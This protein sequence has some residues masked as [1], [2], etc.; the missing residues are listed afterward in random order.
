[1]QLQVFA[2][3]FCNFLQI[4]ARC[5]IS[6]SPLQEIAKKL[7]KELP[8]LAALRGPRGLHIVIP[9]ALLNTYVFN[10]V[11]RTLYSKPFITLQSS[12]I[13]PITPTSIYLCEAN[14]RAS[15]LQRP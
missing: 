12:K 6:Q 15:I 10:N 14:L 3:L 13:L 7:R 11:Y 5:K 1:M 4:V 2:E 9:I 8:E